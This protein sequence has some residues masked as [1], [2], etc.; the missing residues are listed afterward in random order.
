MRRSIRDSS[1]NGNVNSHRKTRLTEA[2]VFAQFSDIFS[3]SLGL[4]AG[5]VHL[6]TDP[7]GASV[8]MPLRRLPVVIRDRAEAELTKMLN[9]GI[10]A[11]VTEPTTTTDLSRMAGLGGLG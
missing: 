7:N 1:V 8:R 3:G 2:D 4:L 9:D 11:S 6:K 5:D 10:I